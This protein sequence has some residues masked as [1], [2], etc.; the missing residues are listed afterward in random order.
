LNFEFPLSLIL[1]GKEE[2]KEGNSSK[3]KVGEFALIHE[4]LKIRK[5]I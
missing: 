1:E 4:I 3:K 5:I 2:A